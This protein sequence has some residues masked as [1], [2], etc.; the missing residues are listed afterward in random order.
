MKTVPL[1]TLAEINPACPEYTALADDASL[2]FL[3]L[4]AVWADDR[5]DQSRRIVK[6]ASAGY[7]RFQAGDIVSPKVT[8][9]FQAGRSMI[10][11]DTGVG[12]SELHVLRA[13]PG[14]DPRWVLYALRSKPYLNEG[15]TAF[16]GVAGLQRV[17]SE[18][19]ETFRV[20]DRCPEDQ[21]RIADFLDDRVSRIDQIIAA[22]RQQIELASRA[23]LA[24][25]DEVL[26]PW[27]DSDRTR[28]G[29]FIH[30]IEQGWSPQCDSTPAAAGEWGVLKVSAVRSGEFRPDENKRLPEG[31][32]PAR[33]FEVQAGDLLVTRANTPALVGA[34]ACVPDGVRPRLILCD[35]IMRVRL[36]ETITPDFAALVGQ[37]RA[38]RDRLSGSGTGTSQS[39]VNIRGEDVRNLPIPLLR[40]HEQLQAVISWRQQSVRILSGARELATQI[41]LLTE[42]K[43]SLITAAVTG[44]FDV[45]TATTK[46]PEF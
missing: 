37:T 27:D 2:L 10:A 45:T 17:P 4:Q 5:A 32:E 40:H 21:R 12:T 29:Y 31:L 19:L 16:Q 39:M 38:V 1:R 8:P 13:R 11:H 6:S 23:I 20:A 9:T 46:I 42:Y 24:V 14:V 18:F 41:D 35:K 15:V 7:T 36:A 25:P 26:R 43:Q 44:E 34:F 28:F 3:P 33:E 30:H 22:R